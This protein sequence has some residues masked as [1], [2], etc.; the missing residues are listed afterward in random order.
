M[1]SFDSD[2]TMTIGGA[3]VAGTSSFAVVNPANEQEF[4]RAPDCSR[5]ELDQAVAAARAAFP[6]WAATPYAERQRLVASIAGVLG[7]NLEGL[8][9]LL[10]REQGKPHGDA[11]GDVMGG[12]YWC[13]ANSTLELPVKV[14]EDT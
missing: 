11:M 9:Q 3:A 8:K 5:A 4:A 12:A 10:T 2:F 7:A 14:V 13:Q 1:T 6:G